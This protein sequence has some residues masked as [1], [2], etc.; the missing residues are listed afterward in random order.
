MPALSFYPH[1][2]L[3]T[4]AYPFTSELPENFL[5]EC[6]TD[7]RF[8]EALY[9]ASPALHA[10]CLKAREQ[11]PTSPEK[12]RRLELS[13]AKYYGRSRS[14]STPFGLFAGCAVARWADS[15][16][17][18]RGFA[19]RHTR[20]DMSYLCSLAQHLEQ[21]EGLQDTLRYYPNS[22]LYE[23]GQELRY[24]E[25]D[26][27]DINRLSQVSS[28]DATPHLRMVLSRA[29]A[30]HS[31]PELAR[32]LP[33]TFP[34]VTPEL[35]TDFVATLIE[36]RLLV[37][38]LE[39]SVTG[40]GYF[41]RLREVL[42][43]RL[44]AEAAPARVLEEVA[45]Q[46]RGLDAAPANPVAA[47]AGVAR[48]LQALG[49]PLEED[50][51][52]QV[53]QFAELAHDT[54]ARSLQA[55]LR[56][57]VE[58]LSRLA[59][60][61]VAEA[62]TTFKARFY[63]RYGDQPRPLLEVL[64]PES[65]IKYAHYGEHAYTP[66][67]EDLVLPPTGPQGQ[68]TAHSPARQLLERKLREA[69]QQGLY[70]VELTAAELAALPAG[71]PL[72]PSLAVMFRVL[73]DQTILCEHAGGSS[74]VNL[75]GRFAY[76]DAPLQRIA[77]DIT[78]QEQQ[79]NPGVVFAEICHLPESRLGNIITRPC[80]RDYEIPYLTTSGAPAAGQLPLQDLFVSVEE[81]RVVLRSRVLD[82]EVVPR[83]GT[84]H[85]YRY[86]SLP[87]YNFLCDLQTQ[88]QQSSLQVAWPTAGAGAGFLP[89]ITHGR[90]V[91]HLATWHLQSADFQALTTCPEAEV[92]GCFAAL[93]QQWG[94]PQRFTLTEGDN[95]L[96]VDADN[97]LTV[98]AW[99]SAIAKSEA[100]TLKE[101]PFE[102]AAACVHDEV[103]QPYVSQLVALLL[104][105]E[106][107]YPARHRAAAAPAGPE[108]REFGLGSEWL[109]Y[110]LYC[111]V[112]AADRVLLEALGPLVEDLQA[113]QLVDRWFFI[114]YADPDSHLRVRFHLPE[115]QRLA[116]VI[117]LFNQYT[118][119]LVASGYI[120]KAQTDTYQ[121]ELERY[122]PA[123][124]ALSEELFFRD[125]EAT[126][127]A[128]TQLAG[129]EDQRWIWGL[130][131]IDELLT[132]FGYALPQK[133]RLLQRA[134][135]AFRHEFRVDKALKLQIDA[136]YRQHRSQIAQLLQPDAA[137]AI[138]LLLPLRQRR[139]GSADAVRELVHRAEQQQLGVSLD[140]LLASHIH[141]LVNRLIPDSQR[142]H[143]LL[144][145]DFL[146]R[147]YQSQT[148]RRVLCE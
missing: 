1:L 119:P 115:P 18:V 100:I 117:Q 58:A 72:P 49:A 123:A 57:A 17:L 136:R 37:S 52:F 55:P 4:P 91:L 6:F 65:G 27:R 5:E 64:D 121:R 28:V 50:K 77:Q 133:A 130:R 137:E 35:A 103:G 82:R 44:P 24:T 25:Y 32:L 85:N 110:K 106:P 135:E 36:A 73:D 23:I 16:H 90:A 21:H 33:E 38:E 88:G 81:D 118:A 102:S 3:R 48:Q 127:A 15:T 78:R 30:G 109:Y 67:T 101:F 54:L 79:R 11:P 114:R 134:T 147:E 97:R 86:R 92:E 75:L 56:A 43:Q 104:N 94:L 47:Y 122:G 112:K 140:G 40:P 80:L 138:D 19:R 83:L 34:D 8:M 41:T 39:P 84:A 69:R 53:D 62:L 10:A 7:S 87:V 139:L 128:L 96:L 76:A 66:L 26:H 131:S 20:L 105:E 12:R 71:A 141:M 22:S 98:L 13:V 14:R 148:S 89:R 144:I 74:A 116:E 107:V 111:G 29:A 9:L 145:Y 108:P 31:R 60:P 124:I 95:E 129:D 142:L 125:S 99:R 63:E 46:L 2:I 70:S 51:L 143:E 126:L 59:P 120:W 146:S 68:F 42:A 61:P 113:R 93:R 45:R 132:D